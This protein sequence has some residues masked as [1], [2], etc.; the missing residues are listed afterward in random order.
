MQ[1]HKVFIVFV[2]ITCIRKERKNLHLEKCAREN[3]I[4][5]LNLL[6]LIQKKVYHSTFTIGHCIF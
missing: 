1:L 3:Q 6:S 4:H 2:L 5:R